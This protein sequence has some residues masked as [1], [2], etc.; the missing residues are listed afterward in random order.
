[1]NKKADLVWAKMQKHGTMRRFQNMMARRENRDR[2]KHWLSRAT[3]HMN[4]F[5]KR[6]VLRAWKDAAFQ[7]RTERRG[8]ESA[9]KMQA[10]WRRIDANKRL[11]KKAEMRRQYNFEREVKSLEK[12]TNIKTISEL[13]DIVS[14]YEWVLVM[15]YVP[16]SQGASQTDN[17]MKSFSEVAVRLV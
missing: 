9:T 15:V 4:T 7:M 2:W 5:R 17:Q 1:L 11:V 12:I 3:R 6:A 13:R 16:W 14:K 10:I 8:D